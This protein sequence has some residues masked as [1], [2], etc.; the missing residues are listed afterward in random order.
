MKKQHQEPLPAGNPLA[1]APKQCAKPERPG[2]EGCAGDL[3]D[4][5]LES[6]VESFAW[7]TVK[8]VKRLAELSKRYPAQVRNVARQLSAWPVMRFKREAEDDGSFWH[9]LRVLKLG[10]DYPLDTSHRAR[11][12]PTSAMGRYLAE[13]VE[14]LHEFRLSIGYSQERVAGQVNADEEMIRRCW[15]NENEPE[16]G[17]S[18]IAVLRVALK[19]QPFTKETSDDWSKRVFVPLI[20]LSDAGSNEKTC[21]AP[22]LLAIWRQKGVKSV[23]TFRSRLLTTACQML[24]GRARLK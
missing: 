22:V 19:L 10:R 16:P 11:F 5:A 13:W 4:P 21:R 17:A 14:R 20:M 6:T 15:P 7:D 2:A 3:R 24:R 9:A 8:Q 1:G 12:H 18:I 23:P